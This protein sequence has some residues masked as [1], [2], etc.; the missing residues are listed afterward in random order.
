[1]PIHEMAALGAAS[2]WALSGLITFTP[3]R[4]LGPFAFNRIKLTFVT[5]VLLGYAT[6]SGGWSNLSSQMLAPLLLSGFVGI[7]LGDTILYVALNRLGPRRTGVL[8]AMNAPMAACL[9]WALLGERI[10]VSSVLGIAVVTAG[11]AMAILFGKRPEQ[12]HDWEA[13]HGRAWVG[14][15]FGL[16]A[17][18]AQALGSILARPAMQAGVDPVVASML[19]VAVAAVGLNMMALLPL[20][21][22]RPRR[23]ITAKIAMATACSGL[24][25]MGLGM[26]LLLYG[27]SGGN[28]GVISTLSATTP[29]LILPMLWWATGQR[30][31]WGAWVGAGSVILGMALLF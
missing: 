7:L 15:G 12:R 22:L 21:L 28:V 14:I 4:H 30:P 31:A 18:L 19:R 1:M 10:P 6:V 29:V 8:F 16:L 25:S 11:V 5:L 2:C 17:A 3:S 23:A 26:T 13:T 27:L 24:L 20:P 9:G